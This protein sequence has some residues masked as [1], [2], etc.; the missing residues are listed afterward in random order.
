MVS[1]SIELQ[2]RN[3]SA[4]TRQIVYGHLA[5]HLPCGQQTLV[6]RAKKLRLNEQGDK[7]KEPLQKLKQGK[8][9]FSRNIIS[10]YV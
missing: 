6:K 5:A 7:L 3:M 2:V 10:D 8:L 9:S 4:S 1:F